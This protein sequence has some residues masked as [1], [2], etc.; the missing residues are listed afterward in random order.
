MRKLSDNGI[1]SLSRAISA[2]LIVRVANQ[3]EILA[4]QSDITM[5]EYRTLAFLQDGSR[6]AGEMAFLAAVKRPTMSALLGG[7]RRKSW[8]S[9]KLDP[10]DGRV[11]RIVLTPSG[12]AR[13]RRF[14]RQLADR[15]EELIAGADLNRFH[16]ILAEVWP[17][18]AGNLARE[19]HEKHAETL[20][21]FN[22]DNAKRPA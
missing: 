4:R 21:S 10:V 13:L 18:L 16:T 3:F 6:R 22:L 14:D 5:A 12:R 17:V 9:D 7:L 8:I 11:L 2:R 19:L 1:K 15:L 20:A